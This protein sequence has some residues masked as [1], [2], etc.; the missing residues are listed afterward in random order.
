MSDKRRSVTVV[1]REPRQ[2]GHD[3]GGGGS[4]ECG[5]EASSPGAREACTADGGLE[6][7]R[8]KESVFH[9]NAPDPFLCAMAEHSGKA[10]G[11]DSTELEDRITRGRDLQRLNLQLVRLDTEP[12]PSASK[13]GMPD[14]LPSFPPSVMEGR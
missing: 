14:G 6:P 2:E 8:R 10:C 1:A 3:R 7:E 9:A 13:V 5:P 12:S 4:A 11:K